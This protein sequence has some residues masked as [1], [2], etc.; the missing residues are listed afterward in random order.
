[1][2]E[3]WVVERD[4]KVAESLTTNHIISACAVAPMQSYPCLE[5]TSKSLVQVTSPFPF[6]T[7]IAS[8]EVRPEYIAEGIYKVE[9]MTRSPDFMVLTRYRAPWQRSKGYAFVIGRRM[10]G[11]KPI[12]TREG[13]HR[14][15]FSSP[16]VKSK[17]QNHVEV[18]QV[19]ND[20]LLR[21]IP[22]NS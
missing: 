14:V 10:K 17:K 4:R 2:S 21:D 15:C 1:M 12:Q 5:L 11:P 3:Q 20:D 19:M 7:K 16:F 9:N 8:S 18:E 13:T 6:H 22:N